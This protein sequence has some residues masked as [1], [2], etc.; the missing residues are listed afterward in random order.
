LRACS[1]ETGSRD[2]LHHRRK[3]IDWHDN[4]AACFVSRDATPMGTSDVGRYNERSFKTRGRENA[5]V[6]QR[7]DN[8]ATRCTIRRR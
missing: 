5:F 1:I 6:T 3:A 7:A 8:R 2:E 4:D